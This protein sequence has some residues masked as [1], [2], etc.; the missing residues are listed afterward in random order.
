MSATLLAWFVAY[1]PGTLYMYLIK[2][3]VSTIAF[4]VNYF[5]WVQFSQD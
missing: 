5:S 4:Y 1:F 3:H 2:V